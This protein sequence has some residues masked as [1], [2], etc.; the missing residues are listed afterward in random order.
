MPRP[1]PR[2]RPPIEESA[3]ASTSRLSGREDPHTIHALP[4]VPCLVLLQGRS[5]LST[6]VAVASA[7]LAAVLRQCLAALALV[8]TR[9]GK[10]RHWDQTN[11]H[12]G[13]NVKSPLVLSDAVQQESV[14][15]R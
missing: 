3:P 10:A 4:I 7:G 1:R 5:I 12:D 2:P 14:A 9:H 6:T 13:S 11:V 15:H 8:E